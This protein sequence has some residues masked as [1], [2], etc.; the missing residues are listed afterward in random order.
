MTAAKRLPLGPHALIST[1]HAVNH[2][3]SRL[4]VSEASFAAFQVRPRDTL[5]YVDL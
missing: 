2:R 3:Y 1:G 4:E 5:C